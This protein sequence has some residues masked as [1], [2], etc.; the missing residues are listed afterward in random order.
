MTPLR[1]TFEVHPHYV[2]AETPTG[3]QFF[4]MADPVA[5]QIISCRESACRA[6]AGE[7]ATAQSGRRTS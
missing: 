2:T 7:P 4:V 6:P 3:R 1:T 5:K